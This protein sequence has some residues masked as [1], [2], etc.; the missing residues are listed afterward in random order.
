MLQ[1]SHTKPVPL[2]NVVHQYLAATSTTLAL[3]TLLETFF[4]SRNALLAAARASLMV[5]QGTWLCAIGRIMFEHRVAWDTHL[6]AP[7]D[8]VPVL[9]CWHVVFIAAGA[10]GLYTCVAMWQQYVQ[11][12]LDVDYSPLHAHG[13][14]DAHGLPVVE[15]RHHEYGVPRA[16]AGG[17]ARHQRRASG[18]EGS[19][20]IEMSSEVTPAG[21]D[22]E[23]ASGDHHDHDHHDGD[24]GS[25][26]RHL[27]LG[28]RGE[29]RPPQPAAHAGRYGAAPIAL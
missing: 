8:Y 23:S 17:V 3:V 2:D 4:L 15:H 11:P 25:E 6:M 20:D 1:G 21:S 14:K 19:S 24:G 12:R 26:R 28:V 16:A 18:S 10:L 5:L 27:L 13:G 9:Y 22:H 29:P 7:H